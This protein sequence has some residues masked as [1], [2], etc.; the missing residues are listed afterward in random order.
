MSDIEEFAKKARG[1]NVGEIWWVRLDD[2]N[3]LTKVKII[4]MT[5]FTIHFYNQSY[6]DFSGSRVEKHR[7]AFVERG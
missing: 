1:P 7:I 5:D 6:S 4:E 3:R 2:N